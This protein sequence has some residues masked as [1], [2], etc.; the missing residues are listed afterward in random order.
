MVDQVEITNVG[1]G[2]SVASEE[3]LAS[4]A[5]AIG[6][7]AK[8]SGMDPQGEV[9]KAQKAYQNSLI[10]DVEAIR[11]KI[12][13]Q[14][15]YTKA[16]NRSTTALSGM[17][18]R[19]IGMLSASVGAVAGS[20]MNFSDTI[21]S[22]DQSLS[23]FVGNIPIF[24][25]SL[26]KVT[27][28]VDNTYDA[29]Q[30]MAQSGGAFN[31]S[32]GEMRI[33]ARMSRMELED[34]A[35]MVSRN[36][37]NLASF[38]GTVSQ[39]QRE[40]SQLVDV[41]GGSGLR[42]QLVGMGLNYEDINEQMS[43]YMYLNRAGSR[44]RA[45]S[46]QQTA[47]AAA[48]LTKNMLT[49]AKLTGKDIKQI[50]EE[51]AAAQT[52][53]AFQAKMATLE[54]N[55]RDK[56]QQQMIEA[57]EMFGEA[58][59]N[60]VK[61]QF[62]GL[63]PLTEEQ[64]L[65]VTTQREASEQIGRVL[66]K[67]LDSNI[68]YE[69]F[70]EGMPARLSEGIDIF[71]NSLERN[72]T[73]LTVAAGGAEGIPQV[74][75]NIMQGAGSLY[76]KYINEQGM[77]EAE[78]RKKIIEDIR[79]SQKIPP[80]NGYTNAIVNL[81]EAL[82]NV[83]LALEEN[84]ITPFTNELLLP[85]LNAFTEWVHGFTV[86]NG[87]G[88]QLDRVLS[89]FK[90]KIHS[91]SSGISEFL[92][93]FSVDPQL[94]VS[95]LVNDISSFIRDAIFGKLVNIGGVG[96]DAEYEIQGGLIPALIN[97]FNS[98]FEDQGILNSISTGV[99]NVLNGITEGFKEFWNSPKTNELLSNIS[100]YFQ[101]L[102]DDIL[103]GINQNTGGLFFRGAAEDIEQRR[104]DRVSESALDGNLSDRELGFRREIVKLD[105]QRLE[106]A[107]SNVREQG[108]LTDELQ[109]NLDEALRNIGTYS[110]PEQVAELQQR[111]Q[112]A[113]EEYLQEQLAQIEQE[114]NILQQQIR[115]FSTTEFEDSI[116][117]WGK[118]A[119]EQM[120]S[121]RQ[122]LEQ[123]RDLLIETLSKLN[124][125]FGSLSPEISSFINSLAEPIHTS[126]EVQEG[127]ETYRRLQKKINELQTIPAD[128]RTNTENI[129]LTKMFD[130]QTSL[131]ERYGEQLK[132][133]LRPP[134]INIDPSN[135][136]PFNNGTKG[137]QD[138]GKGTLAML[139]GKEAVI[140]LKSPLGKIINAINQSNNSNVD[141]SNFDPDVSK[142]TNSLKNS[143]DSKNLESLIL[144]ISTALKTVTSNNATTEAIQ[145]LNTTM[146]NI[147]TV[148]KQTK[149]IDE[150][151]AKNTSSIGGNIANGRV[152]SIR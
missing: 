84:I 59:V 141:T 18:R 46:E 75:E 29:L 102:V 63:P 80:D 143:N 69:Q 139:H 32:L 45:D 2:G 133:L 111:I 19:T 11:K 79:E 121:K 8:K 16:L 95:N 122:S 145:E 109:R 92:D 135:I 134:V 34:F 66:D 88:S 132:E 48:S 115:Q 140:P 20:L 149:A 152:S 30:T 108:I 52:N 22:G 129:I 125:D 96:P 91:I 76:L 78:A 43:H 35:A 99:S 94:S 51:Q 137:F 85:G 58:G 62:L 40:V 47:Q 44:M 105:E 82:G 53:L 87:S 86:D 100:V 56:L 3:T 128:E 138:F 112:N 12:K 120:E 150:S 107:L 4:L 26:A 98:L 50:Q 1:N 130:A 148:L 93:D 72:L 38:G 67:A 89:F 57:Q 114:T 144:E 41:L 55:Q 126:S 119:V 113:Q 42:Q 65:F 136:E 33:T 13:A 27:K 17:F 5:E 54:Q 77:S 146:M 31:Y 142:I 104:R 36:S 106:N 37:K 64:A 124:E 28:V 15:E 127:Y 60:E 73:L 24:G 131:L 118:S 147:L 123:Q 103:L 110:T 49:L 7:F 70:V 101:D 61:R 116:F 21:M 151:I 71:T 25:S 83:K 23:G 9:A 117:P 74:L 90:E 6:V 39:G 97:G 68:K 14:N 10:A 81:R